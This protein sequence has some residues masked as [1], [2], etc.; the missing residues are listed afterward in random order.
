MV[1]TK[2][3]HEF[4]EVNCKQ[5]L[6]LM[7]KKHHVLVTSVLNNKP[8]TTTSTGRGF[9]QHYDQKADPECLELHPIHYCGQLDIIK[10][11]IVTLDDGEF[12]LEDK[13]TDT[14]SYDSD[15]FGSNLVKPDDA[16]LERK[17]EDIQKAIE[18][19]LMTQGEEKKTVN[20]DLKL[21]TVENVIER[22]N[23]NE[24]F[25]MASFETMDDEN[26]TPIQ[27][28]AVDEMLNET[29]G[30]WHSSVMTVEEQG[31]LSTIDEMHSVFQ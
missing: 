6:T 27:G 18:K 3:K 19:C 4:I 8:K 17:K 7:E 24:A 13:V 14:L 20:R 9:D 28:G 25:N 26:G 22:Q 12:E 5:Q 21:L 23:A 10:G 2:E 31:A 15:Y 29:N 1:M 30:A 11:N 16:E